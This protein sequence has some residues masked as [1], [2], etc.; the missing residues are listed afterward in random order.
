MKGV[1]LFG[2]EVTGDLIQLHHFQKIK[3]WGFDSILITNWWG[4]G[5]S[6]EGQYDENVLAKYTQVIGWAKQ[7]GL[8]VVLSMRV[9]YDP[10]E[11]GFTHDYV[12]T[13]S[14][15]RERYCRYLQKIVQNLDADM[16]CLWHYP[17]HMQYPTAGQK[18]TYY[19]TTFPRLLSAV[20]EY[21]SKPI[22]FAPME[23]G[24]TPGGEMMESSY[25]YQFIEPYSDTNIVYGL[26]H[27][28]PWSVTV[29]EWDYNHNLLDKFFDGV[30]RFRG[31]NQPMM[32]I[33]YAPLFWSPGQQMPQSK[34]DCLK[35]S[36]IR[37]KQNNVD[38]FFWCASTFLQGEDNLVEDL[39]AFTPKP[40]T[41]AILKAYLEENGN[42]NGGEEFPW[43]WIA[44]TM[45]VIAIIY[46][47]Q[48]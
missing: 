48:K 44:L 41:Y 40:E 32:S 35:E 36:L 20:R 4:V 28:L 22:I 9:C 25:E 8:K 7:A 17:Y 38:W 19:N 16:Y 11:E 26:G 30:R 37:M 27:M 34:L 23:Q 2:Y 1:A 47:T 43:K 14:E 15:G 42:G 5:E 10:N 18:S 24:G 21:T 13:T 46:F 6:Q 29:G 31:K 33:E 45:G 3:S 39:S 12:N